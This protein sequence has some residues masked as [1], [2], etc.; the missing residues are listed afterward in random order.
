MQRTSDYGVQN[1]NLYHNY[2]ASIPQAQGLSQYMSQ[3]DRYFL[4]DNVFLTLWFPKEHMYYNNIHQHT[5]TD[6]ETFTV[7]AQAINDY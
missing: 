5:N 1:P 3:K 6:T 2:L 4:Q 7:K